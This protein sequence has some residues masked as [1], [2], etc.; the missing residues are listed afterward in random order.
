MVLAWLRRISSGGQSLS[1]D[2]PV[3]L[4]GA[5]GWGEG[6]LA[7]DGLLEASAD[8]G[9]HALPSAQSAY[10]ASATADVETPEIS[11]AL[12]AV[13]QEAEALPESAA[14]RLASTVELVPVHD[15][16]SEIKVLRRRLDV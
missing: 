15:L 14:N 10:P 16:V 11:D 12:L 9:A 5:P 7:G 2:V 4:N 6:P 13:I 8:G 3:E 1:E